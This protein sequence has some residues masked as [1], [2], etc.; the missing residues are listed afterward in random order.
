MY[1]SDEYQSAARANV[2]HLDRL[3]EK[4]GGEG[5][6]DSLVGTFGEATRLEA[7]F[8]DMGLAA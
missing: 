5:R 2:M 7:A 3:L 6:F 1:A 8:W 4:R